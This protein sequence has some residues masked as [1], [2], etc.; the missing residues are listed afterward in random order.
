MGVSCVA[1]SRAGGVGG[2]RS[3]HVGLNTGGKGQKGPGRASSVSVS[4]PTLLC[5][6]LPINL[7][8]ALPA[9]VSYHSVPISHLSGGGQPWAESLRGPSAVPRS[10]GRGRRLRHSWGGGDV[11]EACRFESRG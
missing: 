4:L 6:S 11:G 9:S 10:R 7:F 5:V 1:E 8:S 3:L 2:S